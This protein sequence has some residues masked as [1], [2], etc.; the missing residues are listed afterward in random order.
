MSRAAEVTAAD[1]RSVRQRH[2]PQ[3]FNGDP[4]DDRLGS[5]HAHRDGIRRP[6]VQSCRPAEA[7]SAMLARR[8]P[9]TTRMVGDGKT[10]FIAYFERMAREYPGK[11]V[12]FKRRSPKATMWSST[13][14]RN[15]PGTGIGQGSTS[16]GSITPARWWSTGTCSSQS[17]RQRQT[18]IRC[19]SPV[20]LA[21]RSLTS[22]CSRRALQ[23]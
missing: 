9:S 14:T 5:R 20:D 11:R 3:K 22:A 17:L 13:A 18:T 21:S 16:S 12:E 2:Q 1:A 19:S 23:V 10:A 15:G 6:D 7:G 8:T 4:M